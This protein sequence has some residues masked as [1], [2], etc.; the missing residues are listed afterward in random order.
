MDNI[1]SG[2][3]ISKHDNPSKVMIM[4]HGYGDNAANFVH[5]AEPLDLDEWG[6]HYV[7]LNAPSIM[8]GNPMGYQWFDLYINGIYISDAGP[9]EYAVINNIIKNNVSKINNTI[10]GMSISDFLVINQ[11]LNYAKEIGDQSYKQI[12]FETFNS[13]YISE[14][15]L[16]QVEFRRK[17]F[18]Y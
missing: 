12:G 4:L 1:L 3:A 9:K 14:K 5:L 8:P 7:A 18:M 16:N 10:S 15:M 13:Q 6:M 17:E 11:W 2:P